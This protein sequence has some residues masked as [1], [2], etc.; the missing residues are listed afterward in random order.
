MSAFDSA[1]V[2][3][4]ERHT[5]SAPFFHTQQNAIQ[6]ETQTYTLFGGA[7]TC[8]RK[9]FGSRG[10]SRGC[11]LTSASVSSFLSVFVLV[12]K[13][14][15]AAVT[16]KT[17]S[18]VSSDSHPG[19]WIYWPKWLSTK[20]LEGHPAVPPGLICFD[21]EYTCVWESIRGSQSVAGRTD[22]KYFGFWAQQWPT[23]ACVCGLIIY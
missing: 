23:G 11:F 5:W 8:K 3:Q 20:S 21:H 9:C 14:R 16:T 1:D 22:K 13:S 18:A 19:L 4:W 10:R 2:S 17:N 7:Y 15:A 12:R 6:E